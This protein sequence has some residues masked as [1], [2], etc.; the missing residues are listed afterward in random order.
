MLSPLIYI[1]DS[2]NWSY[3]SSTKLNAI[4]L[5]KGIQQ[6][7]RAAQA[8]TTYYERIAEQRR[9]ERDKEKELESKKNI[10]C[11]NCP[12]KLRIPVRKKRLRITCPKCKTIFEYPRTQTPRIKQPTN[13]YEQRIEHQ[14]G[15]QQ[16]HLRREVEAKRKMEERQ[17]A[18]R[19]A[20]E[21]KTNRILV[22]IYIAIGFLV[23]CGV[24]GGC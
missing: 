18:V 20:E 21:R 6:Y 23:L 8:L 1:V 4:E 14:R 24:N 3:N 7:P 9:I 10:G 17:Q 22:C 2:D 11:P 12:Q 15:E 16:E 13:R 5:L 19:E